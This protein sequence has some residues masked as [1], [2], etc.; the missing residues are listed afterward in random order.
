LDLWGVF[1]TLVNHPSINL[2]ADKAVVIT[3]A[4]RGIGRVVA[5]VFVREGAKVLVSDITGEERQ[6]AKA[7]GAAAV[8]FSAD[9]TREDQIE[10]MFAEALKTF[11]RV[12]ASVH[13]AGNPGGRRGEEVT[14]EEYEQLT[15]VHLRGMLFCSKHAVRAMLPNG[16]GAIVNFS[17][18]ASFNADPLISHVYSAAKAGI[19]SLTKTF[20][21]QYGPNGI[22][23]NAI[24]PGFTLTE[25][26]SEVPSNIMQRL[27]AKAALGRGGLP[28]EQ[29]QVAAFLCS[30]RAAFVSGA[31]IPVDGGWAARLA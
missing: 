17:S 19:N 8:P 16:S 1:V 12:D 9:V 26:N 28:E 2:L 10:A 27:I 18:L 7:L 6:T 4:G 3:G 24:A 25:T 5:Q 20:A 22:R 11:G 30:D 29:A 15:S 23:V 21:I 13:V 14:L 31:V